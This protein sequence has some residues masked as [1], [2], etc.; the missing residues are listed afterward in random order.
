MPR[1]EGSEGEAVKTDKKKFRVYVAQI[2][3]TYYDVEAKD[4]DE[5][6][7]KGE[8]KWRREAW[9]TVIGIEDRKVDYSF[10]INERGR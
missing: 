5:A 7:L 3:Q 9:P 8:R 10:F 2:N 4:K 1:L 6:M